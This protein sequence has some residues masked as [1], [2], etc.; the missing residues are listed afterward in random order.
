MDADEK[1]GE[2]V[3][4]LFDILSE[5]SLSFKPKH[6]ASKTE[7]KKFFDDFF[8]K[9]VNSENK[10]IEAINLIAQYLRHMVNNFKPYAEKVYKELI[11]ELQK[12]KTGTHA[13]FKSNLYTKITNFLHLFSSMYFKI[14]FGTFYNFEK[15]EY[16]LPG[17]LIYDKQNETMTEDNVLWSF[18]SD[19]NQL[20]IRDSSYDDAIIRKS[21]TTGDYFR[22]FSC[23]STNFLRVLVKTIMENTPG[24]KKEDL[25][26]KLLVI[27]N[28]LHKVENDIQDLVV[29]V[30]QYFISE[31]EQLC[32]K[33]NS[34]QIILMKYKF[35]TSELLPFGGT[36]YF[37]N[38]ALG[39]RTIPPLN[40]LK[41][42][43]ELY[44]VYVEELEANNKK[45]T[46]AI[47][48]KKISH[49]RRARNINNMAVD[50]NPPT[51]SQRPN[52]DDVKNK[53]SKEDDPLLLVELEATST[54]TERQ[55]VEPSEEEE[56]KIIEEEI[57]E[58][59][60]QDDTEEEDKEEEEDIE[61]EEEPEEEKKIIDDGSV[62]DDSNNR[63]DYGSNHNLD[64]IDSDDFE[65]E[66][67]GNNLLSRPSSSSSADDIIISGITTSSSISVI[68]PPKTKKETKK[69]NDFD[70]SISD[71]N[72]TNKFID[73]FTSYLEIKNQKMGKVNHCWMHITNTVWAKTV[74][75][76]NV[77]HKALFEI[78]QMQKCIDDLR[79]FGNYKEENK[80]KNL[81]E[82]LL[83]LSKYSLY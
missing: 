20:R 4:L 17:N 58:E 15:D 18:L 41:S 70:K 31:I 55:L 27:E 66:N 46:E 1:N 40:E 29:N 13:Q 19:F 57:K 48:T 60:E 77:P 2:D 6:K 39:K 64:D 10:A 69:L 76:L 23:F 62:D 83:M 52:Y 61:E 28:T 45:R 53:S 43:I 63:W 81:L 8:S 16:I 44:N 5:L 34:P 21:D 30:K 12:L 38:V 35:I 80:R 67:D 47:K 82:L 26:I 73:G 65:N 54:Q 3:P 11:P 9:K 42:N 75:E 74:Y 79:A 68:T 36:V 33:P 37:S 7:N 24:K 72:A 25:E 50:E 22:Y 59:E 49:K 71:S 32:R 78:S 14:I 56:K 51:K